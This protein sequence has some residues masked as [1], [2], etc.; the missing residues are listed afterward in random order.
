MQIHPPPIQKFQHDSQRSLEILPKINNNNNNHNQG[1]L[2]LSKV[3][4]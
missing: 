1:K 2:V 3:N 4:L